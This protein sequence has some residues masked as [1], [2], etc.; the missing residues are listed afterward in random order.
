MNA[1]TVDF[2]THA[3]ELS[4]EEGKETSFS[5]AREAKDF[6]SRGLYGVLVVAGTLGNMLTVLVLHSKEFAAGN[7]RLLLSTLA[8]AD[9]GVLLTELLKVWLAKVNYSLLVK[10]LLSSS[11]SCII[12]Y[13]VSFFM[14]HLAACILMLFTL[15]RAICITM[16]LRG[17]QLCTGRRIRIALAV[18]VVWAFTVNS[19]LMFYVKRVIKRSGSKIVKVSCVYADIW[20]VMEIVDACLSSFVPSSVIFIGNCIVIGRL[21]LSQRGLQVSQSRKS[22]STTATL[23][24]VSFTYLLLTLPRSVYHIGRAHGLWSVDFTGD[25]AK[26]DNFYLTYTCVTFFYYINN[27]INFW[28][29]CLSGSKF[30]RGLK[31]MILPSALVKKKDTSVVTVSSLV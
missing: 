8:V 13:M 23:L 26:Y 24:M 19:Y 18:A 5:M 22:S 15:E 28:L 10:L 20:D 4:G 12:L 14:K 27:A 3:L 29:Y 6:V 21:V 11:K 17:K 7:Y 9:T 25:R 30:R 16:P 31:A 1:T 2:V